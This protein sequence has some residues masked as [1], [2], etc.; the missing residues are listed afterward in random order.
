MSNTMVRPVIGFDYDVNDTDAITARI[1]KAAR[2]AMLDHKRS[3][4]PIVEGKN[5][6]IVWTAAEDIV[7]PNEEEIIEATREY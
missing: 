5:G 6:E 1:R 3:G 4:D 7:I 2:L